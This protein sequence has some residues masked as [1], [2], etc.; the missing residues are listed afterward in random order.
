MRQQEAQAFGHI[1]RVR[2]KDESIRRI[3]KIAN[4]DP[5]EIRGLV[6]TRGLCHNVCTESRPL[7]R[8]DL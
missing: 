7:G 6:N 5:V 8:N 1:R 2:A 4:K 3:R